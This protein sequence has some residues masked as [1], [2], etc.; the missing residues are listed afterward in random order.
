MIS[1][2]FWRLPMICW[3]KVWISA[4]YF[5]GEKGCKNCCFSDDN[6]WWK[7]WSTSLSFV[8]ILALLLFF[9]NKIHMFR[10]QCMWFLFSV[11]PSW[12]LSANCYILTAYP[13]DDMISTV[14]S[15]FIYNILYSLERPRTLCPK[16]NI[17][18]SMFF[19]SIVF[20]LT[21]SF[22]IFLIVIIF[23][24]N[25]EVRINGTWSGLEK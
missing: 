1:K 22:D 17:Q 16:R 20:N 24:L 19:S 8:I 14:F 23:I 21:V 15:L 25:P 3:Y 9:K 18:M 11:V 7:V 2:G 13:I 12:M 5:Y 6:R 4:P 10:F